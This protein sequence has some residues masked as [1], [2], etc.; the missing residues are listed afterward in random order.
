MTGPRRLHGGDLS[1][2]IGDGRSWLDL[3]TGINPASYPWLDRIA[4]ERLA[5]VA[6]ALPQR[7]D[8]AALIDAFCAYAGA[9]TPDEWAVGPGSQALIEALPLLFHASQPVLI[10]QPTYGEHAYA[11]RRAG[12]D[13]SFL[14]HLPGQFADRSIVILTN[15]NNPDGHTYS[16]KELL[17]IADR[18][19]CVSGSLIVD[20]A[21]IDLTPQ[22]SLTSHDLPD[23]VILL[24]SFGKFFGLAGLR[25]GLMRR[26]LVL[27]DKLDALTPLWGTGGPALAIAE[28][29]YRDTAWITA[30]RTSLTAKMD[31]LCQCLTYAGLA[32]VGRTDLYCLVQHPR[33]QALFAH[34]QTQAVHVRRFDYNAQW[35]RFG[36]APG[37]SLSH[38]E[39]AL[40]GDW[41][42]D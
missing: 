24:R 37:D 2:M 17:D 34:L 32:L 21:F 42:H 19:A 25:L 20:E 13:V 11:W 1:D 14:P 12:Y 6:Q 9:R 8:E 10:P 29:A 26:P 3:S 40:K 36:L 35:L 15:P 4:P 38:L 41:T 16:P 30:M 23:N 22:L 27:A 5:A 39:T 28:A 31:T 7:R 33:A 18:L